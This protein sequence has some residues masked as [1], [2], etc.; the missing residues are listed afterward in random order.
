M[1]GIEKLLWKIR[2]SYYSRKMAIYTIL[3][4]RKKADDAFNKVFD[5]MEAY[6]DIY[7]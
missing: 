2:C 1:N 4:D 7:L 6:K 5:M 3:G